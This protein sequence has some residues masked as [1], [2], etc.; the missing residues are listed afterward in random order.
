M[1]ATDVAHTWRA[2]VQPRTEPRAETPPSNARHSSSTAATTSSHG[3]ADVAMRDATPQR[4]RS[5]S[6]AV[7]PVRQRLGVEEAMC[8]FMEADAV[9]GFIAS[10]VE[11]WKGS[12]A[13]ES[14]DSVDAFTYALF[15]GLLSGAPGFSLDLICKKVLLFGR[16]E[17]ALPYSVFSVAQLNVLIDLDAAAESM[18]APSMH[19]AKRM[20]P[21]AASI[22]DENLPP[23]LVNTAVWEKHVL[24]GRSRA[25]RRQSTSAD[26]SVAVNESAVI[27]ENKS[28]RIR[29]LCVEARHVATVHQ[30]LRRGQF[31][32]EYIFQ[33][34][35]GDDASPTQHHMASAA[36]SSDESH[37][38]MLATRA[39]LMQREFLLQF[40]EEHH[41]DLY[42]LACGA[43]N[44]EGAHAL[45]AL[46]K[47]FEDDVRPETQYDVLNAARTLR[48][49]DA[50]D[51]ADID[52]DMTETS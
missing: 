44:E 11:F 38:H 35:F 9:N 15:E 3:S 2:F 34:L 51:A 29:V 7:V 21:A 5:R 45:I 36:A 14:L 32:A 19:R 52:V 23:V 10:A 25:G 42:K 39:Y 41:K 50:V 40:F 46:C 13:F 48:T 6:V 47:L 20:T 43:G 26:G 18:E 30:H 4:A 17:L 49:A 16:T 1:A 24:P 37:R 28:R 12:D 27:L 22:P 33:E 31:L 8:V